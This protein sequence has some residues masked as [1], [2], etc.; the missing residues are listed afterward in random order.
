MYHFPH[1]TVSSVNS[2]FI[3]LLNSFC[4][5]CLCIVK[6]LLG[7]MDRYEIFNR[8][9]YVIPLISNLIHTLHPATVVSANYF[10]IIIDIIFF[11][12]LWYVSIN[13]HCDLFSYCLCSYSSLK[14]DDKTELMLRWVEKWDEFVDTL[15][16]ILL[17][18]NSAQQDS[19]VELHNST[20]VPPSPSSYPT[21]TT[22][23]A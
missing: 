5:L 11:H 18:D 20:G 3:S 9:Q 7:A 8:T 14:E 1:H 21:V 4:I 2:S 17:A 23:G 22:I 15:P 10:E 13:S 6:V 12:F 19:A 16:M